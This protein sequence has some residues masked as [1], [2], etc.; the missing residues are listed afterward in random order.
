VPVGAPGVTILC[1][2]PATRETNPFTAPLSLR[3]DELDG[4]MWL[5]DVFIP[6][7]RVFLVEPSPEPTPLMRLATADPDVVI[8]W[9]LD[10][11]GGE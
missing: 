7:E 3:Y 11:N 10:P 5:D 1:R 9:Q 2:K 4:Q 8:Y 6:W